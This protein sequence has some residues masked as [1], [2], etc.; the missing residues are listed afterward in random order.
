MN[1]PYQ[2]QPLDALQELKRISFPLQQA[3]AFSLKRMRILWLTSAG[4]PIAAQP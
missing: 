3:V 2:T 1:E 4:P